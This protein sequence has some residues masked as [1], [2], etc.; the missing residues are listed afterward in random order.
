MVNKHSLYENHEFRFREIKIRDYTLIKRWIKESS[1]KDNNINNTLF[2]NSRRKWYRNYKKDTALLIYIIEEKQ[3]Y[4]IPIGTSVIRIINENI[5]EFIGFVIGEPK[6]KN[7]DYGMKIIELTHKIIFNKIGSKYSY[8]KVNC[9]D[10]NAVKTYLH[11]GYKIYS[12]I[13]NNDNDIYIMRTFNK[14]V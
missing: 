7:Q 4:G 13:E 2:N 14:N 6:A 1:I 3:K 9:S 12:F 5:V 11:S 10:R 8:L